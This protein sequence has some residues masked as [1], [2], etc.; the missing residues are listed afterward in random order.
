MITE[1]FGDRLRKIRKKM[2]LRQDELADMLG[3]VTKTLQ[4]WEYGETAPRATDIAKLC[5]ALNVTET[6]LL[7]GPSND[8]WEL[9][10][11]FRKE[12]DNKGGTIDMSGNT[13]TSALTIGDKAMSVELGAPFELWA[14]DDKFDDLIKQLRAKR[15]AGLKAHKEGW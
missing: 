1:G 7:N 4:R 15:A 8:T 13:I 11:V 3:V 10:L 9:K 6:E 12:G 14:D 5:E 2:S